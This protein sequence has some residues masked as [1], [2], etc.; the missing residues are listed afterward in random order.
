M[1][2]KNLK[3]SDAQDHAVWKQGR[4]N[5]PSPARWENKPGS[6]KMKLFVKTPETNEW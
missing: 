2:D 3:R 6:R 5:R 1:L 4:K